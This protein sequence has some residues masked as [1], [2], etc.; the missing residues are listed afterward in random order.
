MLHSSAVVVGA[1][2][3]LPMT[4]VRPCAELNGPPQAESRGRS[5]ARDWSGAARS[6]WCWP[7]T[8]SVRTV[9]ASRRRHGAL[10]ASAAIAATT[11][12]ADTSDEAAGFLCYTVDAYGRV[13]RLCGAVA[14]Y[15]LPY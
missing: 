10:G 13:N 8:H 6:I 4:I 14:L 11:D 7:P 3:E 15:Y 12:S 1:A 9:D 5:L 2:G